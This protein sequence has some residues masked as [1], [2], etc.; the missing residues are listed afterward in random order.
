VPRRN[1]IPFVLLAVLSVGA[2]GFAV[3]GASSAPSGATLTVQNASVRTFGTPTGSNSFAVDVVNAVTASGSRGASTLVRQV[4]Y[5]PPDR[6]T[7]YQEVGSNMHL[8]AVLAPAAIACTLS[9]YTAIVGG[10]TPWTAS[11]AAFVRTEMLATYDA[12]VPVAAGTTCVPRQSTAQGTV[13]ERAAVRAGYLVG[14]RVT[15]FVPP[16]K[17]TNGQPTFSGAQTQALVLVEING[18]RTAALGS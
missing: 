10:S 4:D 17:L 15:A 6:M 3:L 2:L 18:T 16:Q 14:V 8:Q 12:R 7:V 13:K 11:G 9:T 1:L 5:K